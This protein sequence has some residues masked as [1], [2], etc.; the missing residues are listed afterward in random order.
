MRAAAKVQRAV[1]QGSVV[2]VVGSGSVGVVVE[3]V[4]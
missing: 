1:V 4:A 3:V 2:V